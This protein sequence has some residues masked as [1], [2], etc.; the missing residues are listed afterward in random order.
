MDLE[1]NLKRIDSGETH[2]TIKYVKGIPTITDITS[3]CQ[4]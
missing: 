3:K 2:L 4:H 1:L